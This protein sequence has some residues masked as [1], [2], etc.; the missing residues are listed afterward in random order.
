V[1][2]GEL[3]AFI[4]GWDMVLETMVGAAAVARS[5]SGYVQNMAHS[6][7]TPNQ[8][9]LNITPTTCIEPWSTPVHFDY[10]ALAVI[11]IVCI[12]M[13]CGVRSSTNLNTSLTVINLTII[14]FTVIYGFIL[15]DPAN[16]H[17]PPLAASA[18]SNSTTTVPDLGGFLPFTFN[19]VLA[20]GATCF[21][22]YAGFD[23]I[24][25]AGEE[26][27]KPARSIPLATFFAMVH[28]GLQ[29]RFGA[30]FENLNFPPNIWSALRRLQ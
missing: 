19:G 14:A 16:W 13:V 24:A 7:P 21:F 26:A 12:F 23:G 27:A 3:I 6:C 28:L 18:N 5:L 30:T 29:I 15:A 11:I 9:T 20:A 4:I 1:C 17:L 2:V 25:T 8:T 22:A 10:V